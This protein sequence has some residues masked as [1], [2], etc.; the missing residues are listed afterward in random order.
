[1]KSSQSIG[2]DRHQAGAR[3]SDVTDI[4]NVEVI[5]PNFKKR[6]SGVT[7]TIIQLI[8][9]QNR[10]GQ[11]VATLGPGLPAFL[12]RIQFSD[13]F[14]LW[15]RPEGQRESCL[16]C[17]PQ[18]R[19]AGRHPSARFSAHAAEDCVHLGLAAAAYP[20]D[21][22]PDFPGRRSDC[23]E[24]QDRRLSRGGKHRHHA[25]RGHGTLRSTPRQGSGKAR[26]RPGS[27]KTCC[28]LL[29]QGPPPEGNGSVRRCDDRAAC[30]PAGLDRHCC[31]A[32]DRFACRLRERSQ[33][34]RSQ[35]R[36]FRP[37]PF[38]RRAHQY[39]RVVSRPRPLCRP[40]NDGKGSA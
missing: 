33:G 38:R 6:L 11:K 19:D 28:R 27:D 5:A 2:A 32:R 34:A 29:R 8:P 10:L 9:V 20:L 3:V 12:P 15:R 24:R 16:A 36:P 26:C 25:W 22:I 14:R 39:Q 21:E 30:R 4:R 23:H 37:H 17:P 18:Q 13:L 40:R 31:R 7:S 1:M 35:G